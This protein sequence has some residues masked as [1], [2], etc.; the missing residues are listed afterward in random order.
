[1]VIFIPIPQTKSSFCCC[2]LGLKYHFK[3]Q[4]FLFLFFFYVSIVSELLFLKW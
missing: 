2:R 1:M 3:N 4:V